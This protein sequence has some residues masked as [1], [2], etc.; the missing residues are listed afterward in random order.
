MSTPLLTT[1]LFIPPTRPELVPRPRLI[2]QLN[3]GLHRK[4]T[5]I[6]AAAGFG[7]TT[8][9]T[10][11][12]DNVRLDVKNETQAKNK[13]AW[14]SLDEGDNDLVRFLTYFIAA[15]NQIKGIEATFGKG[16]LSMLLSPQPPPIETIL[17]S[18]I[19][20]LATISVRIIFVLDDNHLIEAQPIHDA[21]TFLLEH[22]PAQLHL[23]IV[24]RE[25]PH[26]PLARLRS[27]DQ[28]TEL[29]VTDLRFSSSEAA[30]F[31]NQVMGLDLSAE[32]I[33]ALETR[34]EGWIAGLQLA[35]IS[36]QGKEDT[37]RLIKSF[38][39]SHRLVLDYLFEEVLD[40]QSESVKLFLLQTAILDR[41]T[42]SLCDAITGQEN[43][44]EILETLEQANLFIV[45]L[46]EERRWF[47]Y[48]HLFAELLRQQLHQSAASSSKEE[49]GDVAELH[50]RASLWYE[51]NGLEIESFQHAAAANDFEHAARLV[52]GDV[53]PLHLRG[54]LTPVLNWLESLPTTVLDARPSLWVMYGSALLLAGQLTSVEQKL[55]AA[56]AALDGAELDD[57]TKFLV[58]L[59]ASARAALSSY[60]LT[61]QPAGVEQ[62][63]Q[64]AEAALQDT[65]SDE[66]SQD[67]VGLVTPIQAALAIDQHQVETVIVQSRRALEYLP[68]D[69]PFRITP[70]WLLGVA[71][72]L[73]GDR[74]A[75]SRAYT[76]V[77]SL[78]QAVG[79][80]LITIP[81]TIGLGNVQ[82]TENQLYLAAESYRRGLQLRDD[83]PL[84]VACEAYL[85]LA[86]IFY[87]WNDLDAAQQHRQHSVQLA[88]QLENTENIISCEVFLARLK[89]AQ[90]DVAGAAAIL[91]QADQLV[92]QHNFVYR[93]PEV[94]AAQVL[95]SLHQGDLAAAVHLVEKYELPISLAQVHLAQGETSAAL[96]VLGPL[97]QQVDAKGWAD[98]RLNVMVFQAVAHHAHGE[99]E[100]AVQLLGDALALAEPGNFI[101]IFVDEGPPMAR[102]L[103]EALSQGIAPDYVQRLLAAFPD[104][105]RISG[106]SREREQST[107]LIDP[108][109]DREI[110]VLRLMAAGYK[111]KEV[112]DRLVISIN[113][114]RHHNRNIFSKLNV[115]S[116]VQAIER[117]RELDLL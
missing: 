33:T 30:E 80:F 10:D 75:A 45:P 104:A 70:T 59:I 103:S 84:P 108:L 2:E 106:I 53:M 35:A 50:K 113:T 24:T 83:Q 61:G 66:K 8:L 76:E 1:K 58:G 82:E 47:R 94:A 98:E 85:G 109:S 91:T 78:S 105:Q 63:L 79:A 71:Y 20:E 39:G 93:L 29:R 27:Q 56:E 116:R 62:K 48:H 3:D 38:S 52:E 26:L 112:A 9:V 32:D 100:Q 13:I 51:D 77:I 42:G 57:K 12:L 31:L 54:A 97:R 43:G 67:L 21:L 19:N 40:Q 41:L 73:Q 25:D 36:L 95:T 4:L 90:G 65:E 14:L 7:K 17:T 60:V 6:S 18:L 114:V 102:L 86:R 115:N 16:T 110:E 117:G 74:A 92:R 72:Q 68:P 22:Q 99:K 107:D 87:E 28:L 64:A 34:T 96:A 46:D 11:W 69:N 101:R 81:A 111:Y 37:T 49:S 23:V 55:Q 88:R 89:L 5:L 44:Q 15:L